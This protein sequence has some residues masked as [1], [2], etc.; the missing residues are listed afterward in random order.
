MSRGE[1]LAC[2]PLA[3]DDMLLRP[4]RRRSGLL[5]L[6]LM[7]AV[8]LKW[9]WS[10]SSTA[11]HISSQEEPAEEAPNIPMCSQPRYR[12]LARSTA[13]TSCL[14]GTS[15]TQ[16][17][18][19]KWSFRAAICPAKSNKGMF[20]SEASKP[21]TLKVTKRVAFGDG[22]DPA[23]TLQVPCPQRTQVQGACGSLLQL[24]EY[25]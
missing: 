10:P 8:M 7:L 14:G 16:V 1:T 20:H 2:S 19:Q 22:A 12:R 24:L 13:P 9:G 15:V 11:P 4:S 21:I 25:Q 18:H 3:T 6:Y 17:S 23:L 5:S